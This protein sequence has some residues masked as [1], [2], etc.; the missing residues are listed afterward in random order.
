MTNVRKQCLHS[1]NLNGEHTY[2]VVEKSIQLGNQALT[3][4]I[5][6]IEGLVQQYSNLLCKIL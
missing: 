4:D 3:N 6:Y 1:G 2:I 5:L